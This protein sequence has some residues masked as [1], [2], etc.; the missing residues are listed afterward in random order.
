M[1]GISS[2]IPTRASGEADGGASHASAPS[3]SPHVHLSL[4]LGPLARPSHTS[5]SS[6]TSCRRAALR[7]LR[8]LAVSQSNDGGHL[9]LWNWLSTQTRVTRRRRGQTRPRVTT[10]R[11]ARESAQESA[12][13]LER[14]WIDHETRRTGLGDSHADAHLTTTHARFGCVLASCL[15][16]W[17]GATYDEGCNLAPLASCACS[18][19]R[20][21]REPL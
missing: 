18:I 9:G 15:G 8:T 20:L 6:R 7:R 19:P 1:V 10:V 3:L 16:A 14:P 5:T 12:P 17:G 4:H 21:V 13:T 2:A 11:G